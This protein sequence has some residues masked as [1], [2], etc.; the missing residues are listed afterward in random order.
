MYQ[1][2]IDIHYF[3]VLA[4]LVVVLINALLLQRS[5]DLYS[6]AKQM[7]RVMP[8]STSLLFLILFTGAVMMAAKHLDFTLQ[9]IVMILFALLYIFLD[10]YRYKLLKAT[11]K[12]GLAEYKTK[13]SAIFAIE[14]VSIVLIT[15]WLV[16]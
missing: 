9:N 11:A 6:Y 15:L 10:I 12:D 13:A 2:S 1:M 8:V 7:R 16:V 14:L 3:G 4:L 5:S